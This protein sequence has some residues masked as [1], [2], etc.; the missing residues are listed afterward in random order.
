MK[1]PTSSKLF[2]VQSLLEEQQSLLAEKYEVFAD[3]WDGKKEKIS[4]FVNPFFTETDG[5]TGEDESTTPK[6]DPIKAS[7]SLIE[8]PICEDSSSLDESDSDSSDEER[9]ALRP[10][11]SIGKFVRGAYGCS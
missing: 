3:E 10:L 5:P 6:S 7:L 11:P 9:P 1:K 4:R 8:P 2:Q